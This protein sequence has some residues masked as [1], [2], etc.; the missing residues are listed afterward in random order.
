M[1]HFRTILLRLFI[2]LIFTIIVKNIVSPISRGS[3]LG[4]QISVCLTHVRVSL[5]HRRSTTI[6]SETNPLYLF[7]IDT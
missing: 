6:S 1:L 2:V 3:I 5:P 7:I 4:Y